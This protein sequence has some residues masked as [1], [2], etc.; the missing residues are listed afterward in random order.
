[1]ELKLQQAIVATRAGR[2]DVA[3]QLL[4][5]LIRENPDDA[6]AWFL[7]GHI[8]DTPDRQARYLQ[9]A[10]ELD[11]DHAIARQHLMRLEDPPVPAP[12][13]PTQ[14]SRESNANLNGDEHL[15][16]AETAIMATAA[17]NELP[18]WLQDPDNKQLQ[19]NS[20]HED[21]WQDSA[22]V[23]IRETRKAS[24]QT[25]APFVPQNQP[26]PI[27]ASSSKSG[28]VWLV[29]ILVIM[30]IVAA[31]VLGILVLLILI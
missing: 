20:T 9:K 18:E 27:E 30:V 1:M 3:Q 29:R 31:I 15:A 22:A 17:A 25:A 16:P 13:I 11:P 5:Q 10:V 6:N 4:T 8:V 24:E 12:V 28:E 26:D 21:E 19:T 14:E 7:M 23:P 2:T